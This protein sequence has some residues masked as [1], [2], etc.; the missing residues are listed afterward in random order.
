M[1][2]DDDPAVLDVLRLILEEGGYA[3]EA[4]ADGATLHAFPHGYPDL[5]LLD[6]WMSGWDG[7]QLCRALKS[8]DET[9]H[10]P[11]LLCS[12]NR[13]G[14]R[15]AREAGADGFIAKPF[16]MD[17]LLR[18]IARHLASRPAPRC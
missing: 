14:E 11:I 1:V 12:A 5:L 17:T 9:R 10:L 16:D 3:V 15:I 2:A 8:R 13:D 6:I 18:T 4:H 7:G